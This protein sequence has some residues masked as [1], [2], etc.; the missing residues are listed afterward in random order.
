M[1]TIFRYIAH[2]ALEL[3]L[4][5]VVA[6]LLYVRHIPLSMAL[7]ILAVVGC[8]LAGYEYVFRLPIFATLK[9][10]GL[11]ISLFTI[12]AL[13]G[14][15]WTPDIQWVGAMIFAYIAIVVALNSKV[16]QGGMMKG[17][18]DVRNNPLLAVLILILLALLVI[19]R[20]NIDSIFFLSLFAAFFLYR[21]ESR[22]MAAGALVTLAACPPLL[23]VGEHALAEQ[24]AIY[25]YYFLIS[26]V[27]LQILEFNRA[28]PAKQK[29]LF[30]K[31]KI[32]GVIDL[33]AG[34][35]LRT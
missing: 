7:I 11:E 26:T 23:M 28:S 14:I 4:L 6:G 30:V 22:V 29:D 27:A 33:R 19:W 31:S 18:A 35:T 2:K 24:M 21:W 12:L 34:G 20:F 9:R 3:V 10:F 13:L 8:V 1:N 32:P 15:L 16:V 17:F 25:A 5:A